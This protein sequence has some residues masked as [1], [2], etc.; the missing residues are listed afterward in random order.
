MRLWGARYLAFLEVPEANHRHLF[1][2]GELWFSLW[3]LVPE[4]RMALPAHHGW[5]WESF[6]SGTSVVRDEPE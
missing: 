3:L 2:T 1:R 5:G 6:A 4:A